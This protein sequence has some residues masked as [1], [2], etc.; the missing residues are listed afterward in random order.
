MAELRGKINQQ[1]SC[2]GKVEQQSY[3]GTYNIDE[4]TYQ[5]DIPNEIKDF[6]FDMSVDGE[7][8]V[9]TTKSFHYDNETGNFYLIKEVI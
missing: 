1:G 2:K 9:I 7:C 8:W 5:N 4:G 3:L 6:V